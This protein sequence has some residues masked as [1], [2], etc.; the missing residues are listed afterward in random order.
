MTEV[1]A[2]ELRQ[3]SEVEGQRSEVR[4]AGASSSRFLI[5][6]IWKIPLL[7]G[8]HDEARPSRADLRPLVYS[9]RYSSVQSVVKKA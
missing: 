6:G 7:F 4:V 5:H 3:K 2:G 8:G 1:E 9:I